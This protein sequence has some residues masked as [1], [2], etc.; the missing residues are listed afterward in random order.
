M[1]RVH[2]RS[3]RMI[4][5]RLSVKFTKCTSAGCNEAWGPKIPLTWVSAKSE[6][7]SRALVIRVWGVCGVWSAG[8]NPQI[9][10]KNWRS[11]VERQDGPYEWNRPFLWE[12]SFVV[13]PPQAKCTG[14][15]MRLPKRRSFHDELTSRCPCAHRWHLGLF[16]SH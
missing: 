3:H 4:V 1:P 12:P 8:L 5:V 10:P 14:W 11:M 9:F 16:S 7:A 13:R 2:Q 6:E 15:H